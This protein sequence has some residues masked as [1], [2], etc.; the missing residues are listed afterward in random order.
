LEKDFIIDFIA[1]IPDEDVEVI[2]GVFLVRCVGL[3][4]PIDPN[5]L[6]T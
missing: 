6:A 4:G 3:V 2:G 5:F 1:E